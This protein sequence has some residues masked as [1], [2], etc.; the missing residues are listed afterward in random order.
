MRGY[1]YGYGATAPAPVPYEK[2]SNDF[3]I[4]II[5]K[6]GAKLKQIAIQ[7]GSTKLSATDRAKIK[8]EETRILSGYWNPAKRVLTS[9]GY[10]VE[11]VSGQIKVTA[12]AKTAAPAPTVRV[13]KPAVEKSAPVKKSALTTILLLAAAA[14]GAYWYFVMRK[15]SPGLSFLMS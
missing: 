4:G 5:N 6:Y 8:A 10:K 11:V 7:L 13:S 15:K 12:P 9:R 2:Q 1:G 14:G 3:L